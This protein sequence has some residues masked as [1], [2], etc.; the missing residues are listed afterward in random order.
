MGGTGLGLRGLTGL[1]LALN[2]GLFAAGLLARYWPRHD[3]QIPAMNGDQIQLAAVMTPA[4]G[5]SK[6]PV[7]GPVAAVEEPRCL[8]WSHI[9]SDRVMSIDTALREAGIRGEDRGWHPDEKL[10]W[11]VYLPPIK[12]AAEMRAALDDARQRGVQDAEPVRVG[13]MANAISL[14]VFPDPDR[15]SRHAETMLGKGF[16]DVRYGLRP[17]V[18]TVRLVLARA[19]SAAQSEAIRQ[20]SRGI[21]PTVCTVTGASE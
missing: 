1:L 9:D 14:G 8:D 13:V 5:K 21:M 4:T 16:K 6:L 2:L 10:A 3:L 7:A 19:P 11:W 12:D 18:D 15:A 17:S 20:A